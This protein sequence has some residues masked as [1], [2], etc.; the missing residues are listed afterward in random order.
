MLKKTDNNHSLNKRQMWKIF[1]KQ[2]VP[3]NIY[4]H[5]HMTYSQRISQLSNSD[6][7]IIYTVE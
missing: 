5:I 3:L 7:H 1:W 2:K 4:S 6:L